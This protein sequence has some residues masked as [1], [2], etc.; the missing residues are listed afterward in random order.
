VLR[1]TRIL[2]TTYGLATLTSLFMTLLLRG[3]ER[4]P[5][6]VE[7]T[8]GLLNVPVARSWVSVVVLALVT[9]A[10]LGRKRFALWLVALFQVYAAFLGIIA[11]LHFARIPILV[12]WAAHTDIGRVLD[13]V[14]LAVSAGALWWLWH[15]RSAFPGRLVPGSW[16]RAILAAVV[17]GGVTLAIT[18]MF[19]KLVHK[20][21][22]PRGLVVAVLAALGDPDSVR[23]GRFAAVPG[24]LLDVTALLLSVTIIASVA[25]FLGSARHRTRWS[26]GREVR[27]RR[28]LAAYGDTDSLGYFATRRDKDSMFA[29]DEQAVVLYRVMAGVSLA[30][31]DPIGRRESWGSAIELWLAEARE[32]GW[33]PTVL[34]ASEAGAKAYAAAGL[35]VL[36]MGDEAILDPARFDLRRASM[37]PVR[38]AAQRAA[39]AGLVVTLHRQEDLTCAELHEI[40]EKAEAW[41]GDEPERGFS[42]ALNREADPADG[43]ILFATARDPQGHLAGLLSFVPWGRTGVSLDLMRRAPDAPNGVTEFLVSQVMA[44]APTVGIRRVSLNFCMFRSVFADATRVGAGSITRFNASVLG[45]FD[46]F[47][48]LERL[49]RSNAKFEPQWY[50]RFLCY[51]DVMSLP[52][53]AIA[54]ASAEGFLPA[55]PL[56]RFSGSGRSALTPAELAE[57]QAIAIVPVA[58]VDEVGPR[59]SDQTRHRLAHLAALES[60][61]IDPYPPATGAAPT[62]LGEVPAE[63]AESAYLGVVGRVRRVRDH[64]GVVFVTLTDGGRSL[65][66]LLDAA[67]LTRERLRS[68]ARLVD[69]GDLLRV[70]GRPGPSRTGTL[71]LLADRWAIEAKSLHPIPFDSF[72]DPEARLR[73]RSTDLLVHPGQ[74]TLLRQRSQVVRAVRSTLDA[75]GFTEVETPMLHTIHGGAT[76]RPFTTYINAYGLDL[77]LRIAPELYLKR[78]LVAG[79]G[80]IYE[81]GRNFRNEGADA[82]HNPEFTS[83]EVYQPYAD[84]AAMR[85]LTEA[86]V[87]AAAT[88]VHGA[89]RLPLPGPDRVRTGLDGVPWMELD[90][91]F[92]VVPVLEAVSR[93]VGRE[94]T[95]D[96]DIDLLLEL[97]RTHG[98]AVRDDM[99][100][101]AL[102]EELYAEIV[103]PATLAPTF[104]VDFPVETSPL[105]RP[106]R[107]K[108]GLVE[109]WDLVIAGMEVA[110]AYTELT[111]PIDQRRR[112]TAQSLMA[113]AGDLEAMEVDEDFLVALET[114]MPPTGGLGVGIDRLVML[115]TNTSIRSVLTFPFVKPAARG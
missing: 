88:S 39:R 111:D 87:T 96:S 52:H 77:S 79:M 56:A 114:G 71:S 58:A 113:A 101:G 23:H 33:L 64:G 92:A 80:P 38:H 14:S 62:P 65:Q 8:F 15:I 110:T 99:G 35:S 112:L 67:T 91:E 5:T 85:R 83:L 100:P 41:R 89:P 54:S 86:L 24:W 21:V 25:L 29:K 66:V 60:G 4:R 106:H 32:Y 59:R 18:W 9:R 68:F 75:A 51:Q 73:Q 3:A 94:I 95:L 107:G 27:I 63:W 78:L 36:A 2:T 11:L 1:G 17:G 6:L 42:M 69:R 16:W 12:P 44:A 48:Q 82:T 108:P 53:A 40:L 20:N 26:G 34:S 31:G 102:I 104:Y 37:T 61:G 57:V 98:I 45:F 19:L 90:G 13:I 81:L 97:A 10:L 115:L 46:R 70:D 50:P 49:Y 43:R 47:W 28:L 103:E 30:S 7:S 22:T 72:E 105:T 55:P 74:V 84:Y 109:R 93:A 76:A